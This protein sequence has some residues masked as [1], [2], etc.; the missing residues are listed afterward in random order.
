VRVRNDTRGTVVAA[1][2]QRADRL[3]DRLLGLLGRRSLDE[4]E[5]LWIEPCNSVH[6]FGMRF[7][8]DVVFVDASSR[9]VAVVDTLLPWRMTLPVPGA[10]SALELPSGAAARSG[11]VAGD[12]LTLEAS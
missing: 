1:R 10:R 2:V 9:V 11:T 5:G 4:G 3:W 12:L 6:M 7:A 8:I